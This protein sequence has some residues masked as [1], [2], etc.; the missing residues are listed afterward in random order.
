M[1]ISKV[2]KVLIAAG[3]SSP[4][5]TTSKTAPAYTGSSVDCTGMYGGELTYRI[6]NGS[7]A[8]TVACSITFQISPDGTNWF[9]YY[10]IGGDTS[11]S[12]MYSGSV[13]L[14]RG[15]MMLRAIAWGNQTNAV[16]VEAAL[17]AVTG[18]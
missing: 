15:V 9:D 7:S 6:T 17:Q 1:A 4:A 16:T 11:G 8:P 10:T 5:G 2:N 13:I 12:T 3:T 18:I 14:D